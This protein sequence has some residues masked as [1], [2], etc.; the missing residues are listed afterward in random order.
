MFEAEVEILE[1]LQKRNWDL[2]GHGRG[3]AI[4]QSNE[5]ADV[6]RNNIHEHAYVPF[7]WITQIGRISNYF[8]IKARGTVRAGVE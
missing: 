6:L 3:D 5:L 8:Q 4:V 1:Y 7:E 2:R